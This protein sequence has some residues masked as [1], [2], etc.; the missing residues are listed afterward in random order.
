MKAAV[1]GLAELGR[2]ALRFL[3]V[4]SNLQD[5][6]LAAPPLGLGYVAADRKAFPAPTW[7]S[8]PEAPGTLRG[9]SP[10]AGPEATRMRV[11]IKQGQRPEAPAPPPINPG[12]I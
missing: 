9:S 1:K 6:L 3:L 11:L 4:N 5:D 2:Q 7:G 12:G 10:A 8:D